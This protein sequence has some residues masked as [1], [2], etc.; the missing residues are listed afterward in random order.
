MSLFPAEGLKGVV[1]NCEL[2]CMVAMVTIG[3]FNR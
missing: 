1:E 2:G 3:R